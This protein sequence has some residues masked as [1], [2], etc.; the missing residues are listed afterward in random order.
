MTVA[1]RAAE[2]LGYLLATRPTLRRCLI[3][4]LTTNIAAL[5]SVTAAPPAFA[6]TMAGTLNWTRI[7]DSHGVP[8]GTYYLSTV[9]TSEAITEAGPGVVP[10]RPAG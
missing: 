7:T 9:G 1:Q 10:T 5:W 8:L 2:R 6:A 3:L 4:W